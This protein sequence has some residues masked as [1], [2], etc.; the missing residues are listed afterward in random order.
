VCEGREHGACSVS[1]ADDRISDLLGHARRPL[2]NVF[3]RNACQKGKTCK[4]E[5]TE[6][7]EKG[8]CREG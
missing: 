5:A 2:G 6:F 3:V 4:R 8:L 7:I 1:Q